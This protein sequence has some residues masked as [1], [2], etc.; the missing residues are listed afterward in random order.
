MIWYDLEV[1]LLCI[2]PRPFISC[3]S[4]VHLPEG[5][6]VS[7]TQVSSALAASNYYSGCRIKFRISFCT[8]WINSLF[9]QG[10]CTLGND[11]ASKEIIAF[12]FCDNSLHTCHS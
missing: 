3:W 2:L 8:V 5:V 10:G 7:V 6:Q 1:R 11:M 12:N 4:S 9:Q